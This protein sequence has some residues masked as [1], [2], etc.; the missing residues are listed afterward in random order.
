MRRVLIEIVLIIVAF[1]GG[2]WLEHNQWSAA[3]AKA[4]A[5]SA[6]LASAEGRLDLY[7]LQDQVLTLVQDTANKN[8]GD[9]SSVSTTFF[10]N[11]ATEIGRT[12]DPAVKSAL[13]TMLNQ[14]DAI[15]AALAKGDP[16]ARD[17][18]AQLLISFRQ[19]LAKA[20]P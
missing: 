2:Y 4:E 6:Q 10:D 9:A 7:H 15:T 3:N 19:T 14:R 13:Q 1:A 20:G 12:S 5:A 18:F 17:L 8:Y 11:L 16:Q